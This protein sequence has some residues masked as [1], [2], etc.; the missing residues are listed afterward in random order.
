MLG[1]DASLAQSSDRTRR[2]EFATATLGG[3]S[4]EVGMYRPPNCDGSRLLIVF[5]GYERDADSYLRSARRVARQ[6]CMTVLAPRLDRER[7]PSW[8]YQR[9]GVRRGIDGIDLTACIGPLILQLVDW[10][11]QHVS[12]PDAD[13][14]LFGHSAG[15]QMLSRV[16]A[17][18]PLPSPNRIVIANPSSHVTP[19]LTERVP[20]GFRGAGPLSLQK[21]L[22]R[23]YLAQPI[24]IYLGGDDVGDFRMLNNRAARRQGVNRLERGRAVYD[25]AQRLA[26]QKGW[27][28]NWRLVEAPGVGH[29]GRGM[30]RAPAASAVLAPGATQ[31]SPV[32][33][34]I[35]PIDPL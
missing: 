18:C 8:R 25:E 5:H 26:T 9:A 31:P 17:Y 14:V 33:P 4:I 10:G 11:R 2:I 30:L 28:L 7:F 3:E 19:T 22:L 21:D 13:Y 12:R 24:T 15:A 32:R 20:Y 34:D 35:L 6:T 16:A 1:S 23:R 27:T 29:S